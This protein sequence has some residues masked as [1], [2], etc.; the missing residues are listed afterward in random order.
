MKKLGKRIYDAIYEYCEGFFENTEFEDL[1]EP[2]S[3]HEFI[4]ISE[5][6]GWGRFSREIF[7]KISIENK[8]ITRSAYSDYYLNSTEEV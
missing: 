3:I 8:K 6:M 4:D 5:N 7:G 1:P 2:S